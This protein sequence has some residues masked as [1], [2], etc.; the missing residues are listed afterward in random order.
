MNN[1]VMEAKKRMSFSKELQAP[2]STKFYREV[3]E[4]EANMDVH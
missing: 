4:Q 1:V 3:K 2:N